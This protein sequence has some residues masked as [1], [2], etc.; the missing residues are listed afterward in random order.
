MYEVQKM[1]LGVRDP[2]LIACGV[3]S[4]C[5]PKILL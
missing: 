1:V 3:R 2:Q 4:L 5:F